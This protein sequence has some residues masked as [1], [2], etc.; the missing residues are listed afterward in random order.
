MEDDNRLPD[1]WL[2]IIALVGLV[3]WMLA[4]CC[5]CKQLTTSMQDSVRIEVVERIVEVR[6]TAYIEV[7]GDKQT[8][9]TQDTTSFLE[10][11]FAWSRASIV[12]GGLYHELVTKSNRL[13]IPIT[14][15]TLRRDSVVYHNSYRTEIVEVAKPLTWRQ[16]TQ[17]KG[18][19]A[20]LAIF[21]IICLWK[22]MKSKISLL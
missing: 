4:G 14:I 3:W 13:D 12:S 2:F 21:I 5:P 16:E 1:V 11:N 15:P 20:M 18:F 17:I 19:W 7:A 8:V 10:N 22:M 9:T 6:D